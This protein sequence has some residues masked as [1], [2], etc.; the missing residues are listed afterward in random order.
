MAS[1]RKQEPIDQTDEDD[2]FLFRQGGQKSALPVQRL[3]GDGA[4]FRFAGLGD[5]EQGLAPVTRSG[6]PFDPALLRQP[7]D[8]AA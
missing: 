5:P 4:V 2:A 3:R 1:A 8:G 6:R 7:V